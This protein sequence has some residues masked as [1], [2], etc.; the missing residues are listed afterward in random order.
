[1]YSCAARVHAAAGARNWPND[2]PGKELRTADHRQEDLD[3]VKNCPQVFDPV[4]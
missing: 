2:G 1:M 3:A 4:T